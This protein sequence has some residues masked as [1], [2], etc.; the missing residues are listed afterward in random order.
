MKN[1]KQ[2]TILL[3]LVLALVLSSC[4]SS[5]AASGWPGISGNED[6]VF[7]SAGTGLYSLRVK[8]GSTNWSFPEK[9]SAGQSFF[10]PPAVD[11]DRVYVGD[12]KNS[13]FALDARNGSVLWTFEDAANRFI[14]GAAVAGDFIL[15]PNADDVLYALDRNGSL[16]WSFEAGQAL[17]SAPFINEEMVYLSSL[18][19]KLYAL[20]LQNGQKVWETELGGAIIFSPAYEDGKLFV[21][22]LDNKVVALNDTNG[23]IVWQKDA[24][25]GLW[26][27]PVA[28]DGVVYYG[29]MAGRVYAVSA[30]DGSVIWDYVLGEMVSGAPAIMPDGVL[31]VGEEGKIVALDFNGELLWNRTVE[32]KLYTGPVAV[33][34]LLILGISQGDEVLKAFNYE[35]SEIWPF[36]PA[37]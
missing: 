6:S 26:S 3:F 23:T 22:T 4:G 17:W 32:G 34:G 36:T 14:G 28:L 19:H 30:K 29:D 5:L 27:Q 8:D 25:D 20:K 13:F 33:D 9:P 37:K 18:D 35:G 15:A 10:A 2:I 12:Y 31:F 24:P 1:K 16:V 21:A 7:V 11:G